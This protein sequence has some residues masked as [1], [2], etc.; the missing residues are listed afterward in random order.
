VFNLAFI[1]YF[2]LSRIFA[3]QFGEQFLLRSGLFWD[4]TRCN[5]PEECRSY[6]HHGGSLKSRTV[7]VVN[8]GYIL[9]LMLQGSFIVV[10]FGICFVVMVTMKVYEGYIYCDTTCKLIVRGRRPYFGVLIFHF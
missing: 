5:I 1:L 7:F 8:G 10:T 6:Q 2:C 4:I 3:V 9:H